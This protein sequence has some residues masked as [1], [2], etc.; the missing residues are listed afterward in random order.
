MEI[1]QELV[2]SLFHYDPVSGLVTHLTNKCKA[3]VGD[4][5]GASSKSAS[6][7]LRI[8]GKKE[9]EH[10]I[11][12]LYMTGTL[13]TLE[14]DHEDHCR[15]NNKWG[16]LREV[17]HSVNMKNKPKYQNNTTGT[18]GVSMDKRCGK[19]RAY[20]SI[21]GKPKGLGYFTSYE[22]AVVARNFAI[23]TTQGYHAN[24]GQ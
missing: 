11:I 19:F 17:S 6:R 8:F 16:N 10:R 5:A 24:H 12:W 22:A 20:L 9:L 2:K 23:A 7:Y 4:R 18:A 3:K 1:T 15:G 13:P 21:A 14:I